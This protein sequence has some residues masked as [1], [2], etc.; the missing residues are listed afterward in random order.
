MA[1]QICLVECKGIGDGIRDA[2][3]DQISHRIASIFWRMKMAD[4]G[5]YW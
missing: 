3:T 4:I 5:G 2:V 1:K